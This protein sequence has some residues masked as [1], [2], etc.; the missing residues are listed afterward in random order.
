MKIKTIGELEWQ[1][2][3]RK[4]E[5]KPMLRIKKKKRAARDVESQKYIQIQ[6]AK[7]SQSQVP[8]LRSQVSLLFSFSFTCIIIKSPKSKVGTTNEVRMRPCA[9]F[10]LLLS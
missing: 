2:E 10:Y 1:V 6:K 3:S 7:Y 4:K 5:R 9:S 8:G